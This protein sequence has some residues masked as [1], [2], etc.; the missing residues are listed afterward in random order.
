MPP[1]PEPSTASALRARIRFSVALS[2]IEYHKASRQA[3]A[4][5]GTVELDG[6]IFFDGL[7]IEKALEDRRPR[8][9]DL[10]RWVSS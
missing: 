8:W 3:T 7:A 5:I 9:G 2:K 10:Y 6:E 4:A 1:G